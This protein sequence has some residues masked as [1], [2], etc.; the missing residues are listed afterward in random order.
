MSNQVIAPNIWESLIQLPENN[1][2][3]WKAG[4]FVFISFPKI[5]GMAE[6]HPFSVIN[7]P[8]Q[9]TQIRLLILGDGDFTRQL[10]TVPIPQ[11]LV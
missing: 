4:D 1:N 5:K 7:A 11:Q 2:L 10:Q 8:N 9:H 3:K 6:P